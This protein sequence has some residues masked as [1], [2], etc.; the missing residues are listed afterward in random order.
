MN[1]SECE[2]LYADGS[3]D[4]FKNNITVLICCHSQN[5]KTD[6]MLM[7]SLQS[8]ELQVFKEFKVLLVLDE[9]HEK[10]K[11]HLDIHF[12]QINSPAFKINIIERQKKSGLASAKNFALA[13]VDTE[14][15]CFQDADD[16]SMRN[17]LLMQTAF[18]YS[19]PDMDFCFTHAYNVFADN[20]SRSQQNL[21]PSCFDNKMYLTHEEIAAKLTTENILTHG[22]CF[23]KTEILKQLRYNA[24]EKFKGAEDWE[25][26]RRAILK[27]KFAQLS[28]R[29]YV[30]TI[31]SSV[32]R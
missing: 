31:G 14:Y 6:F 28:E 27:Y 17:R 29:L 7:R 5:T 19:N 25:L 9:C 32:A 30:Y 18:M 2:K 10:T 12:S 3:L 4:K 20:L 23:T 13:F 1:I 15:V 11:A 8:L 24:D 22:S 26:W 21:I 16:Y